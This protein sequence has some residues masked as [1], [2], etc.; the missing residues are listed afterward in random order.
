MTRVQWIM[1]AWVS[2]PFSI[3]LFL[4]YQ[5]LQVF[6]GN[7]TNPIDGGKKERMDALGLA[8]LFLLPEGCRYSSNTYPDGP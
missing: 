7:R 6:T 3:V 8:Y 2:W 5:P 1:I 4:V